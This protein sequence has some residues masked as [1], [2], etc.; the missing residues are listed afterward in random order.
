[1]CQINIMLPLYFIIGLFV[2][3]YDWDKNYKKDYDELKAIGEVEDGIVA[4]HMLL[5]TI[6]WPLVLIKNI[7]K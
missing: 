6:F 4:M 7:M 2:T 1:M 5:T 3:K